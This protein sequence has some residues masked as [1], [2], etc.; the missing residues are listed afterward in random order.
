MTDAADPEVT[1][2]ALTDAV[3]DHIAA[4]SDGG[5]VTGWVLVA[6]HASA[7]ESNIIGYRFCTPEGQ[8]DHISIGILDVHRQWMLSRFNM[9]GPL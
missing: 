4:L 9:E 2:S 8:A 7:Q 3:R 1:Y 5:L 6:A